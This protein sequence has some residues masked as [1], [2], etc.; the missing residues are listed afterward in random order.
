MPLT[1][2]RIKN[3]LKSANMEDCM[4]AIRAC[5]VKVLNDDEIINQLK[6]LKNNHSIAMMNKISDCAIAA[7]D[8]MGVEKYSGSNKKIIEIIKTKYYS[9][10]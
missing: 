2:N 1:L 3:D 10:V 5:C 4:Y 8:I 6:E 9:V 7:L